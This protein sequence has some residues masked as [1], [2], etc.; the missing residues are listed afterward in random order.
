M[1]QSLLDGHLGAATVVDSPTVIKNMKITRNMIKPV[2]FIRLL[3]TG[4]MN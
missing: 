1:I 2:V 4:S 3:T